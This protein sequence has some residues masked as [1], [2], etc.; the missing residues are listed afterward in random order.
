MTSSQ[1][2]PTASAARA[3]VSRNSHGAATIG[4]QARYDAPASCIACA[5]SGHVVQLAR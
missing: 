4:V 2:V 1:S 3:I 5:R